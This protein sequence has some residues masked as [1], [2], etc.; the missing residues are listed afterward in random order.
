MIVKKPQSNILSVTEGIIVQGCNMQGKMGSG[1]ASKILDVYPENLNT[2]LK[3]F[4][5]R[6][7]TLGNV[8]YHEVNDSLI[9]ANCI[10]QVDYGRDENRVYA[11]YHAIRDAF[12]NVA[13][14]SIELGLTVHFPK[15]GAGLAKG[16]WET[17]TEIIRSELKHV[18]KAVYHEY[19]GLGE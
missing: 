14:K 18:H 3:A 19:T 11:N 5:K 9:I 16:D 2:Y 8:I 6:Q 4:Q 10:T 7:L 17:I 1:L 13:K 15:I 12:A